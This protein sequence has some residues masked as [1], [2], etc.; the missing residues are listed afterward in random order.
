VAWLLRKVCLCEVVAHLHSGED[1]QRA[2]QMVGLEHELTGD[3]PGAVPRVVTVRQRGAA[4]DG[5]QRARALRDG[6]VV[7]EGGVDA[8]G[9]CRARAVARRQK[10]T[11]RERLELPSG[12]ARS[13]SPGGAVRQRIVHAR[14]R[15]SS[16]R[17]RSISM[18]LP[19]CDP[20]LASH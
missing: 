18:Q 20:V 9:V 15:V 11:G 17:T 3:G 19:H 1:T 14:V 13:I 4:N 12:P 6:G 2:I 10:V 8:V 5:R 16:S 7:P